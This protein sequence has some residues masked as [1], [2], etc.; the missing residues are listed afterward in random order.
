[1]ASFTDQVPTFNPYVSKQPVDAMVQ[2]GM[3]KQQQYDTNLQKIQQTMSSIAGLQIGREVDKQYL[4]TKMGEM[5]KQLGLYASS[6]LSSNKLTTHLRS[7]VGGIAQD[8]VVQN[9]VRSTMAAQ[10]AKQLQGKYNEAGK[11]SPSND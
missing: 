3:D 9:S 6:D 10:S 4:E 5:N 1:M 7:M 8:E 2:V 11:G